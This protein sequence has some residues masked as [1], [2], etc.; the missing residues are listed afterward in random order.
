MHA[1]TSCGSHVFSITNPSSSKLS[2]QCLLDCPKQM[3][4]W[5]N[6]SFWFFGEK[7]IIFP[8]TSTPLYFKSNFFQ[9]LPILGNCSVCLCSLWAWVNPIYVIWC[10]LRLPRTWTPLMISISCDAWLEENN[11]FRTVTFVFRTK[12]GWIGLV[13][14]YSIA[15]V[16]KDIQMYI[17]SSVSNYFK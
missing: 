5:Y 9:T 8:P 4:S 12:K 14:W 3:Y 2:P 15:T 13:Y 1:Q 11:S 7:R 6:R 17:F 16:Y 10:N